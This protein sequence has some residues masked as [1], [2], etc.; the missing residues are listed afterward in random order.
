MLSMSGRHTFDR[1]EGIEKAVETIT[2]C[3][4]KILFSLKL[5]L[6]FL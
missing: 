6:A 3:S 4:H 1:I 2:S 5:M